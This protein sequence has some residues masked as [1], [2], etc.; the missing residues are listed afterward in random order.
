MIGEHRWL[1]PACY[2]EPSAIISIIRYQL[3]PQNY[4]EITCGPMPAGR[5]Q[6]ERDRAEQL[7]EEVAVRLTSWPSCV[8]E[9]RHSPP[10][11]RLQRA[12]SPLIVIHIIIAHYLLPRG[13]LIG[14]TALERDVTTTRLTEA[15]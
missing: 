13:V 14:P 10:A 4:Y 9:P 6:N 1:A 12:T 8:L 7:I 5:P 3:R 15:H 2:A 11:W